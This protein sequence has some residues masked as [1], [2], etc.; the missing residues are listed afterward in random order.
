MSDLKFVFDAAELTA[1]I[2][3]A[4]HVEGAKKKVQLEVDFDA[5]SGTIT[6]TI[7]ASIL[8]SKAG[9]LTPASGGG[10]SHGCPNPPCACC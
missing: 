5:S 4:E 10:S 3:A 2:N 1:L 7:K 6:P 8:H 9:V